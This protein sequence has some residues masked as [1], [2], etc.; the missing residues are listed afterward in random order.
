MREIAG[1]SRKVFSLVAIVIGK[2]RRN[3]TIC[4]TYFCFFFQV[5][6]GDLLQNNMSFS[7]K[8]VDLV[9]SCRFLNVLLAFI[10]KEWRDTAT[11]YR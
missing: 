4:R 3:I 6:F 10:F 5:Q 7:S 8:S 9:E 2:D 1:P 11:V